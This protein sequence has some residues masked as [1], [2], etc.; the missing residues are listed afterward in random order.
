MGRL[1][2]CSKTSHLET[3]ITRSPAQAASVS[4]TGS[5]WEKWKALVYCQINSAKLALS[6]I[7]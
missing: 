3:S 6:A 4:L 7:A 2:I 5:L 1:H